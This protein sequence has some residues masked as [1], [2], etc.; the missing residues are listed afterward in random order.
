MMKEGLRRGWSG[1]VSGRKM[2]QI[3]IRVWGSCLCRF[4]C[5]LS[6]FGLGPV[7]F[8]FGR[9]LSWVRGSCRE[10]FV[11]EFAGS[12]VASFGLAVVG[13]IGLGGRLGC[14]YTVDRLFADSGDTGLGIVVG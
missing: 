12:F 3:E 2:S 10:L 8:W 13:G 1:I 7:E 14:Y 4:V 9:W 11:V 6:F 5:F